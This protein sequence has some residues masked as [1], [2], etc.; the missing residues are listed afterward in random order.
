M[1]PW[2]KIA[3]AHLGTR[4]T[5]GP[6]NNP[7]IIGWAKRIGGWIASFYKQ[8]S[9]PWCGLFV[10]YVMVQAG[11]K[12]GQDALSALSWAKFGQALK[13]PTPGAILVF[14]R[15]GGGH[16]GFYVSEDRTTF[17]VLGGNQSDAV[18]LTRISKDRLVAV[19][20][21]PGVPLPKTGRVTKVFTGAISV[22][23]E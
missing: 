8:D 17:H 4:E 12:V 18:T 1:T 20:W 23:E 9:I 19:R 21:P 5:P 3:A 11:F 6:G 10:G 13:I 22:N 16:V 2:L 15:P 7:K 14:K